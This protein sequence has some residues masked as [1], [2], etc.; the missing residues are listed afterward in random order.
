MCL[1]CRMGK[2]HYPGVY[3]LDSSSQ[4]NNVMPPLSHKRVT[5]PHV[6]R[7]H[8]AVERPESVPRVFHTYSLQLL[9]VEQSTFDTSSH[10]SSEQRVPRSSEMI[11]A[12]SPNDPD[13]TTTSDPRRIPLAEHRQ[14]CTLFTTFIQPRTIVVYWCAISWC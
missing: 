14:G 10:R 12:E 4:V 1:T 5:L 9:E 8:S 6:C 13:S 11:L 2:T 7:S 3:Q